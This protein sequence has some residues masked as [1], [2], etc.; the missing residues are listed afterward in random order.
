MSISKQKYG[1][2]TASN[3]I[4]VKKLLMRLREDSVRL[5]ILEV[6]DFRVAIES[7]TP[8]D[9]FESELSTRINNGRVFIQST[10]SGMAFLAKVHNILKRIRQP[11]YKF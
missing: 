10:P 2:R 4:T 8:L 3:A 1:R 5:K 7:S 11:Q 9:Q 6:P